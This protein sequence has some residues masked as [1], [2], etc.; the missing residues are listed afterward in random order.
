MAIAP[1]ELVRKA[2][3]DRGLSQ[4]ELAAR[5][6]TSQPVISAIEN[7]RRPVSGVRLRRLTE[8]AEMRPSI[9]LALHAEELKSLAA[10]LGLRYLSVFGSVARGEDG[11]ES[12]VD[13]F[14]VLDPEADGM[15]ALGFRSLASELLGFPVDLLVTVEAD[16]PGD[17]ETKIR[18]DLILL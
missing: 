4:A 15:R 8:A 9:P 10:D 3:L 5:A 18:E 2:R 12:D 17:F 7:G 6:G 13:L 11:P 14:A 16:T 1:A